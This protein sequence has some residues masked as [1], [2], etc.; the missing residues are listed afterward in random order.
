[1]K[2]GLRKNPWGR[3]LA[4]SRIKSNEKPRNSRG[5][6]TAVEQANELGGQNE[7]EVE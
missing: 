2:R 4:S 7:S 5:K 1:M 6:R 3:Y